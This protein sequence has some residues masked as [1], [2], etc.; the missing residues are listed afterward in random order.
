VIG[1]P[2]PVFNNTISVFANL[3]WPV[4]NGD[5]VGKVLNLKRLVF[6]NDFVV[7]GYGII[8]HI[9]E[10][11]DY[12]KLN[13]CPADPNGPIAMIGAGTGLGHGYL[14]KP[15]GNKYYYVF[16]SEGGH[17]SFAPQSDMDWR[18]HDFLKQYHKIEHVDVEIACSG[19]AIPVMLKFMIE[20]ENLQS[21]HFKTKE[22]IL[23]LKS[24]EIINYGLKKQCNVCEKVIEF[25]VKIYG[26]A[27]GNM[28][29]L[30]LP[31]GGVYLL[32]GLSVGL[33]DYIIKQDVFRV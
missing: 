6:L 27:A 14:V 31:T 7:N 3:D 10:G 30:L 28:S 11:V 17:Q 22:E 29:L 1:L 12:E 16:P 25:F 15:E 4:T 5:E 33:E 21:N 8:S 13:D 26:A 18:Y 20:V 23:K 9:T 19:P 24:E 32:G 2:G